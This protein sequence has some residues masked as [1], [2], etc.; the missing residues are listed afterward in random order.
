[1]ILDRADSGGA[2]W[3]DRRARSISPPPRRYDS[4]PGVPFPGD[5]DGYP[6][7]DEVVAYLEHH[8]ERF[9]LP[10]QLDSAV[11]SPTEERDTFVLGLDEDDRG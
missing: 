11:T 1:V 9:A 4:L 7:H 6:T 2:A 8:A 3:R 5:A 10:I